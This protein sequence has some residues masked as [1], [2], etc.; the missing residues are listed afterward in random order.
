MKITLPSITNGQDLSTLNSNFAAI[1]AALNTQVLYR[2]N[3]IGEDNTIN[4]DIDFNGFKAYNLTDVLVNGVSIASIAT[5]ASAA[6][7][8]AAASASTA[9]AQAAIATAAANTATATTGLALLKVNNLSDLPSVATAK[10]NL[11]LV[12]ADVGLSSVDNTSDVGK[13]VST[14]Q[15]TAI[16]A[17]LDTTTAASTYATITNLAL[18]ANA[19]SPTVTGTGTAAIWNTTKLTSSTNAKMRAIN[20]SGQSLGSGTVTT[21]T[22]WTGV[23][24]VTSSFVAATG[25]FTVPDTGF[26]DV[27][28][29]LS[30]TPATSTAAST[31]R[32]LISVNGTAV[33][34]GD[35]VGEV[36]TS[37]GHATQVNCL[38]SCTAGDLITIQGLQTSGA[39]ATLVVSAA[40][41][42]S[43]VSIK[44]IP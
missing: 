32:A 5:V 4:Q 33:A 9:I 29:A 38:L 6:A 18:K 17:K 44:R 36:A 20:N 19:A 13:P 40:Q 1:M 7:T 15:A 21:I 11:S 27:S 30:F 31:F 22:G 26:Y 23:F 35:M 41:I 10:T 8:Q 28:A 2:T 24:D 43:Y 42:Y 37:E 16:A 12:K 34:A 14:A 25:V 39:A 3:L